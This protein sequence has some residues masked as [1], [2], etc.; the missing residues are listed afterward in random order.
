MKVIHKNSSFSQLETERFINEGSKIK[1]SL[2]LKMRKKIITFGEIM[3]RLSPPGFLRF[4]QANS[5]EAI[6]GGA[7]ANVAIALANFGLPVDFVT[8]LPE[9]DLGNSCLNY[10]RQFGVGINNI[11]RGGDRLGIYFLEMGAIHR[12]SKVIYDRTNSAIATIQ[13]EMINWEN[14]FSDA[15]W[16][17][18]SGITP[19]ISERAATV[20]LAAVKKAKEMGLTVSCDLNYRSKLWKWGKTPETVMSELLKYVDV[21]IANEEAAEK[22]LGIKIPS[23]DTASGKI[24]AQVYRLIAQKIM[25]KYSNLHIVAI[26]H[27]RTISASH[28]ILSGAIFDGKTLFIGPVHQITPIVDRVGGGDAFTAGFIYGLLTF[29]DNPQKIVNFA[30]ASSCLKHTIKGDFNIVTLEEVEKLANGIV[31]GRVVR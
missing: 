9:N 7:E 24:D 16:F 26:T 3:L 30:V 20:C 14:V 10:I 22:V 8:R 6:Y 17:H 21:I 28:N 31:S 1:Q 27:R 12:S 11:I 15:Q 5:F 23:V 25:K 4:S 13:P 19:A 29:S 18:W 2:G